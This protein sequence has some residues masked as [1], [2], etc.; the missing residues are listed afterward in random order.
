MHRR[1]FASFI[2]LFATL[3]AAADTPA[4]ASAANGF[5]FLLGDWAIDVQVKV[6]GL[7]ALIHGVPKLSG[8]L[9]ARRTAQGIEDELVIVDAS[10]NPRGANRSR[11]SFDAAS[12]RWSITN[13][14]DYHARQ[15]S[16]VGRQEEGE[17]RIDGSYTE[18]SETTLTR[19]RYYAVSADAFRFTQDRSHDNG[20]TW[21]EGAFAYDA[22]R[23]AAPSP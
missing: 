6:S 17:M 10:G 14:D 19:S 2:L 13:S 5:D 4:L 18:G 9:K 15:G 1:L 12:G 7:A 21:D 20:A 23:I 3:A 22:R 11:R 8:T 16:A